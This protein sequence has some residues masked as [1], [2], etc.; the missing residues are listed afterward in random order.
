M[1][2][3]LNVLKTL[4]T[5]DLHSE[6]KRQI[7]NDISEYLIYWSIY[8]M[9]YNSARKKQNWNNRGIGQMNSNFFNN[10]FVIFPSE[11]KWG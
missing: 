2:F 10:E 5:L 7:P 9:F 8:E 3:L 6:K 11:F 4:S 1:K